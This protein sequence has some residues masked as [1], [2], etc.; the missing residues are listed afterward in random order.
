MAQS[1]PDYYAILGTL[2][3]F[4]AALSFPTISPTAT[5][6]SHDLLLEALENVKDGAPG[7]ESVEG[8]IRRSTERREGVFSPFAHLSK[9][10]RVSS[11]PL[12]V[13]C[14]TQ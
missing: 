13:L 8:I 7:D 1:F 14:S 9:F 4:L 5:L 10:R 2:P 6:R 12:S 3:P 11:T